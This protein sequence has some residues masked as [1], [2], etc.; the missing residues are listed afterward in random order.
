[1]TVCPIAL[2]VGCKKCPMFRICPAKKILGDYVPPTEP[3]A[4]NKSKS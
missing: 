3:P 4:E 2:A 1:M